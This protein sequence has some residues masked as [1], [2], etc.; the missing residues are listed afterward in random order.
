[1]KRFSVHVKGAVQGVG[2]RPFVYRIAQQLKLKGWV[3]NNPSGVKIEVE[4]HKEKLKKFIDYLTTKKPPMATIQSLE[5]NVLEPAGYTEFEIRESSEGEEKTVLVLPDIGTCSECVEEINGAGER[6]YSYPFTNCTNCGP[7]YTIIERLPYDRANTTMKNFKMC[8]ECKREYGL[9]EDRRFHAQPIACPVCGP[10]LFFTDN[11]GKSV[12]EKE[13]ALSSAVKKIREGYIVGL[14]G[15][16]GF[17]LLCDAR[18]REAVERL[19]AKKYREE[20]PFALMYPDI[21]MVK[22]H[23]E[24]NSLEEDIL[25]S[26]QHPIILL[27]K[28]ENIEIAENVAP[29]NPYLGVMLPYTP[30]HYI[31]M[32]ELNFP[33]IATSGNKTDDPIAIDNDEALRRLGDIADHFLMHNRPILRRVDDS[34]VRVLDNRL[35]MLRRARGYAPLPIY[36]QNPKRL[37]ILALGGHLKN[38]ISFT[39]GNNIFISQHVGDLETFEAIESFKEIINSLEELYEFTPDIITT[40][41]HPGYISTKIGEQLAAEQGVDLQ[42]IQHHHAHIAGCMCE[43]DLDGEVLGVAWDGV[44]YGSDGQAWG[45][46]FL[47]STYEDFERHA[48]FLPLPLP[49]GEAAIRKA[50]HSALGLLYTTF[51]DEIFTERFQRLPALKSFDEKGLALLT[52]CIKSGFNSPLVYGVGR[53]FD[54]VSSIIGIRQECSFEAQ[55]AMELEF[56]GTRA[57]A[58][59]PHSAYNYELESGKP[60]IV[61]WRPMIH[62]LIEDRFKNVDGSTISLKFHR[63]LAKMILDVAELVDIKNV[64]LSGGVFQNALLTSLIYRLFDGNKFKVY[65]HS[66]I[67]PNDGGISIGQVAIALARTR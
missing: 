47:I 67:P 57:S 14:K 21:E 11:K 18:N 62:E 39:K 32:K 50:S 43:N 1:M 54:A 30:L 31:L 22:N 41:M 35:M 16:G 4:G 20:K 23:C 65:T 53:L 15:L 66:L 33:V 42:R 6:R 56:E 25:K 38:T 60:L 26:P 13:D 12:S 8:P 10:Q 64:V 3:V 17:L 52:N 58:D 5:Y 37:S 51:G 48:S 63:T 55:A 44:G 59:L 40:D 49:G 61:D 45:S 2:F 46:E 36:W 28:K 27:K 7:R 9:P 24:V 34:V 19:R 29:S